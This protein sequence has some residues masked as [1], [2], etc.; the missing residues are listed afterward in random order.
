MSQLAAL[1]RLYPS[2][3]LSELKALSYRE[4]MYWIEHGIWRQ[5]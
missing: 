2:W 3:P 5:S 4:R 1:S